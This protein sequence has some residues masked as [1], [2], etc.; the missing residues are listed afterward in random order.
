VVRVRGQ[1]RI[2]HLGAGVPKNDTVVLWDTT[3][4]KR[5]HSGEGSRG[6][7]QGKEIGEKTHLL[8]A[9]RRERSP[10]FGMCTRRALEIWSWFSKI[11]QQEKDV[12]TF[13]V[14]LLTTPH[15][16]N[17]EH[18]HKHTHTHT[19][20]HTHTIPNPY[21]IVQENTP[22]QTPFPRDVRKPQSGVQVCCK[23]N[24]LLTNECFP[25]DLPPKRPP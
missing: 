2:L 25:W 22:A 12:V 21:S 10:D 15:T 3:H 7:L 9:A 17:H 6:G 13:C 24:T 16:N 11:E 1:L 5:G 18:K 20:T 14:L 4:G 8:L 19:N 23:W